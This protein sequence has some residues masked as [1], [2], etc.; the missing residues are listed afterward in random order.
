MSRARDAALCKEIVEMGRRTAWI[1][2]NGQRFA[3]HYHDSLPGSTPGGLPLD[4]QPQPVLA[5]GE[6]GGLPEDISCGA[7]TRA[8]TLNTGCIRT[9][10]PAAWGYR[11]CW[12]QVIRK[13]FS[14]RERKA[15]VERQTPLNDI[16]RPGLPV[17]CWTPFNALGL[18]RR[19]GT[20]T[21]CRALKGKPQRAVRHRRSGALL[22]RLR[23]RHALHMMRHRK[24][25][26]RDIGGFSMPM[27]TKIA[28]RTARQSSSCPARP[29]DRH[30]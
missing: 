2:T 17:T 21:G 15:D 18:P 6:G 19:H 4:G 16:L 30:R 7:P 11:V 25:V 9:V 3:S 23:N 5:I 26:T 27:N 24:H 10:A 28:D 20:P 29:R 22:H 1:H 8:L 14:F 12:E 13:W